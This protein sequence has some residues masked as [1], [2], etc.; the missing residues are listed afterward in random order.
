MSFLV[1]ELPERKRLAAALDG[2]AA[3]DSAVVRPGQ[4]YAWATSPDG[5]ELKAHGVAPAAL[6]PKASSVVAVVADADVAWH[7]ITLPKAPGGRLREALIG[8]LEDQLL[9]EPDT[10]HLALAPGA[11][12][13][14]P[15]WVAAIERRWLVAQIAALERA[16]HLVDR[17]VPASWPD[18]PPTG[19]FELAPDADSA[20]ETGAG[21]VLNWSH[22][23]GVVRLPARSRLT[24]T[25]LPQE[26]L[27][28]T[29]WTATPA[30]IAA[31][32]QWSG[33]PVTLMSPAQRALQAARSTLNLRQFD[34]APRQRG[35]RWLRDARLRLMSP[36]WRPARLGLATLLAVQV[37]GLNLWAWQQRQAIADKRQAL[38][39]TLQ[40]SFPQVR[41]VLDAPLQMQREVERLRAVAGRAGDGDL[42]PMLQA[43]SAAWPADRPAVD[44]LR[45]EPGKLTL[46]AAGWTEAQIGQFRGQLQPAGWRVEVA[47][48]RLTMSRAG[49]SAGG[50]L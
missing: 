29:R 6:L 8:V 30:A 34:L 35:T 38:V 15:A 26:A 7:R 5:L 28:I 1:V 48:G 25:L 32:Q 44:S 40:S 14:Q 43:A 22:S 19:H 17:V 45:Y 33:A 37:L 3:G 50:S 18:H 46:S 36:G 4:E 16:G 10:V 9:D 12:P 11:S 13:G 20:D 41:A 2:A 47:D 23:D 21:L 31:A 42:E 49:G 24:R 39:A 27:P